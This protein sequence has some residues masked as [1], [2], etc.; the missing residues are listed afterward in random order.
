MQSDDKFQTLLTDPDSRSIEVDTEFATTSDAA[1]QRLENAD[2]NDWT[3]LPVDAV[4][5][6]SRAPRSR[7]AIWRNPGPTGDA[8][9]ALIVL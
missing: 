7:R 9:A 5:A 2:L 1:E 8:L 6:D 3:Y 4:R